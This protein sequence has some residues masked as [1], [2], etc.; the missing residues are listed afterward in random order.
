MAEEHSFTPCASGRSLRRET[1]LAR[2]MLP[3][4]CLQHCAQKDT[5]SRE[6]TLLKDNSEQRCKLNSRCASPSHRDKNKLPDQ[7]ISRWD[8]PP[9][10]TTLY[11]NWMWSCNSSYNNCATKEVYTLMQVYGKVRWQRYK[12]SN[13]RYILQQ[14]SRRNVVTPGTIT[15]IHPCWN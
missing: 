11:L 4:S 6:M 2:K 3:T 9:N 7:R 12:L 5:L 8:L 14:T 13:G 10:T 1:R 15:P